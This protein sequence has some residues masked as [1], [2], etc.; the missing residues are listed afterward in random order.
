MAFHSDHLFCRLGNL[1]WIHQMWIVLI[2]FFFF[3]QCHTFVLSRLRLGVNRLS[4]LVY[5]LLTLR[6][7]KMENK[8]INNLFTFR[9]LHRFVRLLSSGDT[10]WC[11]K[12]SHRSELPSPSLSLF[13]LLSLSYFN[14]LL[15]LHL[16]N[17][18]LKWTCWWVERIVQCCLIVLFCTRSFKTFLKF[19]HAVL[20]FHVEKV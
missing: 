1:K 11:G 3:C 2:R 10:W 19:T 4:R 20:A 13:F 9:F 5:S 14:V 8:M 15:M 6:F 18:F 12:C 17:A 16:Q 7:C